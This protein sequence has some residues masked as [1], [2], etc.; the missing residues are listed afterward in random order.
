MYTQ[1]ARGNFRTCAYCGKMA[2][3]CGARRATE[4]GLERSTSVAAGLA[5]GRPC[6][7][8]HVTGKPLKHSTFTVSQA[9][10]NAMLQ[11]RNIEGAEDGDDEEDGPVHPIGSPLRRGARPRH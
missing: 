9:A 7:D 5:S 2:G 3:Q 10:K 8:D 1:Y 4:P 6:M 11:K